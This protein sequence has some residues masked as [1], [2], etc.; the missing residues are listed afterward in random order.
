MYLLFNYKLLSFHMC[1]TAYQVVNMVCDYLC[2]YI[3][4][5][6]FIV[7]DSIIQVQYLNIAF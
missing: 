3:Y 2:K 5:Y 6:I 4:I 1:S 7:A